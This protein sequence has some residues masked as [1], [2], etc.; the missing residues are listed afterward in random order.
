M[1]KYHIIFEFGAAHIVPLLTESEFILAVVIFE[2]FALCFNEDNV[3]ALS[4]NHEIRLMID[5]TIKAKT[6]SVDNTMPP[7]NI[8]KLGYAADQ[9]EFKVVHIVALSC[10]E[11]L[12]QFIKTV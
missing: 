12:F 6:F 3:S 7:N 9:L 2:L 8:I 4:S 1:L 11:R 5:K 10:V